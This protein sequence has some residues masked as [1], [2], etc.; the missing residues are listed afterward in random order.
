MGV[1]G[2]RGLF[3][4]HF[5]HMIQLN[6]TTPSYSHKDLSQ[7]TASDINPRTFAEKLDKGVLFPEVT[8]LSGC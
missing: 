5:V 2:R 4:I 3:L 1:G 7:M 6:L 8:K